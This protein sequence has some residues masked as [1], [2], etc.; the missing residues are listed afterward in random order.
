MEEE[1]E[2]GNPLSLPTAFEKLLQKKPDD[3]PDVF[4]IDPPKQHRCS[5]LEC[6]ARLNES[7]SRIR[8]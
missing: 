4:R 7:F 5:S 8:K 1:E 6:N 3:P 2:E